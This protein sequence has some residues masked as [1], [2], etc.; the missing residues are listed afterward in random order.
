MMRSESTSALGQP[1]ETKE[2]RGAGAD[3]AAAAFRW[4]DAALGQGGPDV[5]R[6]VVWGETRFPA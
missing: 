5:N 2:M 3:M 1:S 6:F 4:K